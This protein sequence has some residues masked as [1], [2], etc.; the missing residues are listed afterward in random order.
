MIA[1]VVGCG[2]MGEN[3]VRVYSELRGIEDVLVYDPDPFRCS[4]MKSKYGAVPSAS[5]RDLLGYCDLVSIC[6]PTSEHYSCVLAALEADVPFLVEK[7]LAGSLGDANAV[8][9][10]GAY[11]VGSG[12]GHIERFNPLVEAIRSIVKCPRYVAIRRHNPG[13]SRITDSSVVEDL[14]IHDIDILLHVIFPGVSPQ[15]M[16]VFTPDTSSV[17]FTFG[18]SIAA[19]SASR[20][21]SEK[22]RD[23][24][25]EDDGFTLI[26]DFMT[27]EL[28]IYRPPSEFSFSGGQY[29]QENIV[30]K[31]LVPRTEPLKTEL[32]T[33]IDCVEN[34]KPFPV[35]IEQAVQNMEIVEV[36][37]SDCSHRNCG[38]NRSRKH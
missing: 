16:S 14:M 20:R 37:K 22:I 34:N 3:H 30:E 23:I 36:I 25:I 33:F 11:R 19:V 31:V 29:R 4:A 35:S 28:K 10:V 6:S 18:D 17:L 21:G 8:N 1:G 27:Q 9:S 2:R 32:V 7:P 38:N 26:G 5:L 24:Y 13:S 12:V 15:L